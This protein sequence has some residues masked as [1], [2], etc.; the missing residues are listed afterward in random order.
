MY[1]GSRLDR[2]HVARVHRSRGSCMDVI[3]SSGGYGDNVPRCTT[4][5]TGRDRQRLWIN[6]PKSRLRSLPAHPISPRIKFIFS[7]ALKHHSRTTR[8]RFKALSLR[9]PSRQIL[10]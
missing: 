1:T 6:S 3:A 9:Q 5:E 4:V 8:R 7:A 10:D 2:E